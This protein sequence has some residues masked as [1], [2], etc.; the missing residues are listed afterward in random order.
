MLRKQASLFGEQT[1]K[2]SW[3][4]CICSANSQTFLENWHLLGEHIKPPGKIQKKV[5]LEEKNRYFRKK[6]RCC[7]CMLNM[8]RI[9]FIILLSFFIL[10][11]FGIP[12]YFSKLLKRDR[13][14]KGLYTFMFKNVL[15]FVKF[16]KE[17]K[18]SFLRSL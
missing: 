17:R 1:K 18:I 13:C 9:L 12:S 7:S 5:L 16:Q 4:I 11:S 15:I 2:S 3:K 14:M 8:R 6:S 10:F